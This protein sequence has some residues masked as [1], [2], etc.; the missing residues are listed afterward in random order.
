LSLY[1][2]HLRS[3]LFLCLS[4]DES[5]STPLPLK[6]SSL[7]MDIVVVTLRQRPSKHLLAPVLAG[8]LS[9]SSSWPSV[10][11]DDLGLGRGT[12]ARHHGAFAPCSGATNGV[13]T[14][15]TWT[16]ASAISPGGKGGG[17]RRL[18]GCFCGH[19]LCGGGAP[20]A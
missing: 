18:R 13:T 12:N 19:G 1:A 10:R 11:D 6:P 7:F 5:T 14:E 15:C 8:P 9:S 17:Q 16:A 20:R 2:H 4:A 3:C